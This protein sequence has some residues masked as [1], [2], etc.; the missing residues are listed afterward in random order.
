MA[1]CW[2]LEVQFL[3]IRA[4]IRQPC[5]NK[6]LGAHWFPVFRFKARNAS[7]LFASCG[8]MGSTYPIRKDMVLMLL[9]PTYASARWDFQLDKWNYWV[10]V[11]PKVPTGLR[12]RGHDKTYPMLSGQNGEADMEAGMCQRLRLRPFISQSRAWPETYAFVKPSFNYF[13]IPANILRFLSESGNRSLLH[14]ISCL[15]TR[16]LPTYCVGYVSHSFEAKS[17]AAW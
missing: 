14:I 7:V 15:I 3:H 10:L 11:V 16:P 2:S 6:C 8:L 13:F 5:V 1:S 17:H 12:A 9:S 4:K